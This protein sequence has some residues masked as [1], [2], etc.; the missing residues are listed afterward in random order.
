[1]IGDPPVSVTSVQ[2]ITID[3]LVV[4]ASLVTIEPAYGMDWAR[5]SP[6]F[7]F[8]GVDQPTEFIASIVATIVSPIERE[9]GLVMKTV[10]GTVHCRERE[11]SHSVTEEYDPSDYLNLMRYYVTTA[12]LSLGVGD[13]VVTT[14]TSEFVVKTGESWSGFAVA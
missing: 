1:M 9:N 3:V 11:P 6:V 14:S 13:Q 7:G 12:P 10:I 2:S 5:A 8:E 4:D